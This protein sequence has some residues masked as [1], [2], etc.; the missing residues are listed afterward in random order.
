MVER[1]YRSGDSLLARLERTGAPNW[2]VVSVAYLI[3][4][5]IAAWLHGDR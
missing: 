2:V 3:G 5:E 1:W 4:F